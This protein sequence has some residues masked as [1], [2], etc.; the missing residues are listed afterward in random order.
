MAAAG[1]AGLAHLRMYLWANAIIKPQTV[2]SLMLRDLYLN[3]GT[4]R[5]T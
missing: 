5:A 1:A 3:S 4:A 2:L